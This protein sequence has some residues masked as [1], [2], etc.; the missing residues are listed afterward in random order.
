MKNFIL[1]TSAAVVLSF[2]ASAMASGG[3]GSVDA[4]ITVVDSAILQVQEGNGLDQMAS[5]G[6]VTT[7]YGGD[8]DILVKRSVILQAQ[9]GN[10][11]DQKAR[12]AVAGCDC[13]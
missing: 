9:S 7:A 13:E 8:A 11:S 10:R 3:H 12:M 2:S 4:D 6:L 5:L 1:A